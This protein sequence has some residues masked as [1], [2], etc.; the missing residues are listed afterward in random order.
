MANVEQETMLR[1]QRRFDA[2][3]ERVFDAWTDPDVLR[4]WWSAMPAM[5]PGEID[6]DLREGG[7]YRMQMRTDTGE[8]HTV[9]GEYKEVR[10]P[11]R[12]AYTWTWES[13]P[14]E[15]AGSA[16]TLV[17]VEF[18]DDGGGTMVTLTHT[19]FTNPEVRAMHDHGWNGTF[20]SLERYLAT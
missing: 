1:L 2:P 20:D 8:V 4:E 5:S 10:R 3:R 12:I 9:V 7:R 16:A 6:V 18:A 11:E 14:E 13:N 15:M 19:G 17:E